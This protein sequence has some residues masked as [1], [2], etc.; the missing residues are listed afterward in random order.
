MATV[1]LCMHPLSLEDA[2]KKKKKKSLRMHSPDGMAR[3][4]NVSGKTTWTSIEIKA[5]LNSIAS[6]S[7]RYMGKKRLARPVYIT[8]AGADYDDHAPKLY[9][10]K[11]HNR[12][13]TVQ[14]NRSIHGHH[15]SANLVARTNRPLRG[16]PSGGWHGN[17]RAAII[18]QQ[19]CF[20]RNA[21]VRAR[22]GNPIDKTLEPKI[23]CHHVKPPK[24]PTRINLN[25]STHS[26]G[27][28]K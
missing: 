7:H 16:M 25:I 10:E 13:H 17:Q 27:R 22:L 11:T 4:R 12:G 6:S 18:L 15:R 26:R 14:Y 2:Q 1:I 5:F 20:K 19:Q 28:A 8:N 3:A 9:H 21:R 23:P 24:N